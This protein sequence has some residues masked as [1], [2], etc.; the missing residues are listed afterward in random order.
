MT[1]KIRDREVDR[2]GP[3]RM[4]ANYLY[5]EYCTLAILNHIRRPPDATMS[6]PIHNTFWRAHGK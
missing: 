2:D 5:I 4:F 1:N 6:G 3:N